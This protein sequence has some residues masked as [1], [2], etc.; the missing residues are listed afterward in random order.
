MDRGTS[1]DAGQA[2]RTLRL[3]VGVDQARTKQRGGLS[4]VYHSRTPYFVDQAC[5]RSGNE[6]GR[7]GLEW[8]KSDRQETRN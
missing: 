1:A 2:A 5:P 8:G 3:D 7:K 6:T 4:Y